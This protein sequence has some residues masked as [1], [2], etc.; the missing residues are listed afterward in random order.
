MVAEEAAS[1]KL[2]SKARLIL[3]METGVFRL[4]LPLRILMYVW[5]ATKHNIKWEIVLLL[6]P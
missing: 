5:F 1:H 3:R 2:F 6:P 4:S